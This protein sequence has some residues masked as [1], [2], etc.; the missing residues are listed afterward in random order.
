M[1]IILL[2]IQIYSHEPMQVEA[3][4]ECSN[5]ANVVFKLETKIVC[6]PSDVIFRGG[7]ES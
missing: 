5:I 1:T 6:V 2:L 7:F 3:S 4:A